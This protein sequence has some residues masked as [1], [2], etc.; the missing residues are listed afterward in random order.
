MKQGERAKILV[1]DDEAAICDLVEEFLSIQGYRVVSATNGQDGLSLFMEE[2]P[3]MVL[4]D[5]RMPGL[6]GFEVLNEM[7]RRKPDAFVVI[8]SAFG[9]AETIERALSLGAARY[10]EKPMELEELHRVVADFEKGRE[11]S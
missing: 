2:K 5:I 7:K 8:L 9:D 11:D 4:L 6:S 1:I 10:I 3:D